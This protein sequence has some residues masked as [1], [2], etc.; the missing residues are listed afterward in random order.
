M[1]T[2]AVPRRAPTE[3]AAVRPDQAARPSEKLLT[4]H[5]QNNHGGSVKRLNLIQQQIAGLPHDAVPFHRDEVNQRL[6]HSTKM[7][8]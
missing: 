7:S 6:E 4:S 5:H 3:T 8:R 1:T 2:F